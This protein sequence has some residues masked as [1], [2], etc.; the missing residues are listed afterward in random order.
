MLVLRAVMPKSCVSI[1]VI[2]NPKF[3]PYLY[4]FSL[5]KVAQSFLK[6]LLCSCAQEIMFSKPLVLA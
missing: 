2:H 4:I 3:N 5:S 6:D 1:F